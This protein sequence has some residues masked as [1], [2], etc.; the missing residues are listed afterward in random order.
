MTSNP[1]AARTEAICPRPSSAGRAA[2]SPTAGN[3]ADHR[4]RFRYGGQGG[5]VPPAAGEGRLHEAQAGRPQQCSQGHHRRRQASNQARL[6]GPCN[7]PSHQQHRPPWAD[8]AWKAAQEAEG[9]RPTTASSVATSARVWTS[10]APRADDEGGAEGLA[11]AST[12]ARPSSYAQQQRRQPVTAGEDHRPRGMHDA[13]ASAPAE[14]AGSVL[15][16]ARYPVWSGTSAPPSRPR[17]RH[18]RAAAPVPVPARCSPRRSA[19]RPLLALKG[20]G[21]AGHGAT[22]PL[23]LPRLGDLRIRIAIHNTIPTITAGTA[24]VRRPVPK[25]NP[26]FSTASWVFPQ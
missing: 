13:V 2:N 4:Q 8:L 19:C 15:A 23:A 22:S 1:A 6:A 17:R 3:S 10:P 24:A 16:A 14:P 21:F 5:H 20:R 7:T 12:V 25:P 9:R 26:Q 18:V 11:A